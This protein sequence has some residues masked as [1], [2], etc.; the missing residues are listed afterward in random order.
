[1][2]RALLVICL[3]AISAGLV[4]AA[5]RRS[6]AAD[7]QPTQLSTRQFLPIATNA[8]ARNPFGV[9]MYDAVDDARGLAHMRAAGA[10]TVT[11]EFNWGWVEP[12]AD[13]RNWEPFDSKVRNA[14]AAG[15]QVFVMFTGDP[16][17]AWRTIDGVNYFT[18]P[19]S[20]IAFVRA[21][22][23]RYDCDGDA[24]DAPGGLCIHDWSFYAEPDYRLHRTNIPGAKGY[25]GDRPREYGDML[26]DVSSAI[27]AEDSA[28]RVMIGG[29]AYDL[30]GTHFNRNF[31]PTVLDQ[32][33]RKPGQ[34]PQ[35]INAVA[36]HYYPISFPSI[37]DKIRE[38]RAIMQMYG[39]GHLPMI[40]PEMGSWSMGDSNETLQ[41]QRLVQMYTEGLAENV[42]YMAWFKVF[43]DPGGGTN[44][45]GLFRGEDLNSPKPSYDAYRNLALRY[46]GA[47][48]VASFEGDGLARYTFR[49][50]DGV[51][52]TVAWA[53]GSQPATLTIDGA[54]VRSSDLAGMNATLRDG[55]GDRRVGVE[56]APG[57]VR[58][59]SACR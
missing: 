48:F 17:W 27:R 56:I 36:F 6:S 45:W 28:A 52:L 34:A 38:I 7:R 33:N 23:Q 37:R 9:V 14:K 26:A 41:A 3:L 57:D 35:Y 21:M 5:D 51:L 22:I 29:I 10:R 39:V 2:Q 12:S 32:L 49:Q 43:D 30:F 25:W 44:T 59:L 46:A 11:T 18:D 15:M 31:L 55:S 1:M 8:F 4:S 53:T 16:Q 42:E 47:T 19:G 24:L 40:V 58:F 13:V 54:C 50:A 20:R